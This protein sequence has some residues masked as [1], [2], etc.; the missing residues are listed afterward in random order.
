[1]KIN[2]DAS[3]QRFNDMLKELTH[4]SK[5]LNILNTKADNLLIGD[6]LGKPIPAL[7]MPYFNGPTMRQYLKEQ[8]TLSQRR[9]HRIYSELMRMYDVNLERGVFQ[10]DQHMNNIIVIVTDGK[11]NLKQIDLGRGVDIQDIPEGSSLRR[12]LVLTDQLIASMHYWDVIPPQFRSDKLRSKIIK[13]FDQRSA[14][15]DLAQ[16]EWASNQFGLSETDLYY[17]DPSIHYSIRPMSMQPLNFTSNELPDCFKLP[18]SP[19]SNSTEKLV[20]NDSSIMDIGSTQNVN[21]SSS[22]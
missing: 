14:I 13:L 3:G 22:V 20:P 1:V 17:S 6:S 2:H 7:L 19:S 15:I 4:E 8:I 9:V 21:M 5:L 11:R 16:E 18:E 12:Y 10:G